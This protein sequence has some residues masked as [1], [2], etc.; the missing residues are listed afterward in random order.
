M[1]GNGRRALRAITSDTHDGPPG[2]RLFDL[3]QLL[4]RPRVENVAVIRE[5]CRAVPLSPDAVLCRALGRYKIYVDPL[6]E[7]LSPHLMLDGF[8]E[9]W[10]TEAILGF[11]RTGMTAVDVGA[12]IG[13]FTLLLADL[14]GPEGR[15][16]AA[17][18]NPRMMSLMSR[19][20]RLNGFEQRV[21]LHA[22]PLSARSGELVTLHVPAG[23]P[24]NA[25]LRPA[26]GGDGAPVLTTTTLD[27]LVGDGPVDFIKIDA[28]GA[29]QA[30]WQGMGRVLARQAPLVVFMEFTPDRYPDAG[31]FLAQML[32]TGFAL[33]VVD[34]REGVRPITPAD[35]LAG[36]PNE[37]RMLV[38][39]R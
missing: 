12:N 9:F 4:T 29:E 39:A 15:V 8:W 13:Y 6:D 31:A 32:E 34:H 24:Q 37:D 35:V 28:E 5:M 7:G 36:P 33:S 25:H 3:G 23:M 14:V 17:E 2:R 21:S 38:L 19:S 22:R 11:V 1:F 18:P 30:I 26:D 16:H 10:N 27:E 20:V